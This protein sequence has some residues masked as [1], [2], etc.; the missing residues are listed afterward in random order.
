MRQSITLAAICAAM[1]FVGATAP[2]VAMN[3]NTDKFTVSIPDSAVKGKNAAYSGLWIGDVTRNDKTETWLELSDRYGEVVYRSA[4]RA[5]ETHLLP[6]GHAI[7]VQERGMKTVLSKKQYTDRIAPG[8]KRV[9]TQKII[10][11]RLQQASL[12]I[13]SER[14]KL[15]TSPIT[16]LVQHGSKYIYGAAHLV[17]T[18][19]RGARI[20]W[21]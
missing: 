7:T 4:V 9:A 19:L 13:D 8:A 11:K 5:N 15:P 6:S 20:A 17:K 21:M 2:A 1:V 12:V 16:N 3:F 14:T 18:T 10:A